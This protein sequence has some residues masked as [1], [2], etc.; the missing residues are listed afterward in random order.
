MKKTTINISFV[1]FALLALSACSAA[2]GGTGPRTWI[3]APLAGD[4]YAEDIGTLIVY[5]HASGE[6]PVVEAELYVNGELVRV[7]STPNLGADPASFQQPWTPPGP[8]DYTLEV[9]AL[10]ADGESGAPDTVNITIGGEAALQIS[11]TTATATPSQT[12]ASPTV[13]PT[14]TMTPTP[15]AT[16]TLTLTPS[17]TPSYTPHPPTDTPTPEPNGTVSGILFRDENGDGIWQGGESRLEDVDLTL[18]SDSCSGEVV[19][20]R[21]TANQ[22]AYAIGGIAA[23]D[24]CLEVDESSLPAS[25]DAWTPSTDNP[26]NLS[27]SP[28]EDKTGVN[29]GFIPVTN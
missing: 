15:T 17:F 28:G 12:P 10:N 16:N 22:G 7:D 11:P 8:G 27:F 5:S 14:T 18:R 3:D 24:Y 26:L 23:G 20:E 4:V 21:T 13:T 6:V 2:A 19:A 9:R 1:L 25:V 29:F